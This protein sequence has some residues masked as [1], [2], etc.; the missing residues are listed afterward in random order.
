M[1]INAF[2]GPIIE[3]VMMVIR[4]LIRMYHGSDKASK[5]TTEQDYIDVHA[6]PVYLIFT[7]Y[8]YILLTVYMTM[9]FGMA[10]PILYPIALV[11]LLIFYIVDIVMLYMCYRMPP[12]Y[13]EVVSQKALEI[14]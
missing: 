6:G 13:D 11:A 4:K 14:L 3:C 9:F 1:I 12:T 5:C 2:I 7:K 10:L 8:S